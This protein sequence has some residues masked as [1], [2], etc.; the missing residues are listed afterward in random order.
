MFLINEM[1]SYTSLQNGLSANLEIQGTFFKYYPFQSTP[2]S[3][4]LRELADAI[5]AS[6]TFC[7]SSAS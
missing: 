7:V 5:T 1:N 2:V 6:H 3:F 4:Q